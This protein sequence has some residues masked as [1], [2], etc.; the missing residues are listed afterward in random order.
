MSYPVMMLLVVPCDNVIQGRRDRV[1]RTVNAGI[2]RVSGICI[3][4]HIT[5]V[6][7]IRVIQ[8]TMERVDLLVDV[9]FM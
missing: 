7:V 8:V 1:R 4:D 2:I 3:D 5:V 6:D 9:E